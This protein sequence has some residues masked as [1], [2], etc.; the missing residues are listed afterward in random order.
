M[1]AR[2][3][4]PIGRASPQNEHSKCVSSRLARRGNVDP[5]RVAQVVEL[6]IDAMVEPD[7]QDLVIAGMVADDGRALVTAVNK[8]DLVNDAAKTLA[9]VDERLK[10]SSCGRTSLTK[11]L[12]LGRT[13]PGG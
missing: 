6:M 2:P 1:K 13:E 3:A 11:R 4:D 8:W 5:D 9:E 7:R 10:A 12:S